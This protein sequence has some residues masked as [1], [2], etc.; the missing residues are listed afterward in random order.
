MLEPSRESYTALSRV[1]LYAAASNN[2]LNWTPAYSTVAGVFPADAAPRFELKR[3][4]E[5]ASLFTSFVRFQLSV[6]TPGKIRLKFNGV[7]G[8]SMWLN[9]NAQDM[10]TIADLNLSSGIITVTLSVDWSKRNDGL[11]IEL[12][13]APASAARAD[14]GRQIIER[15]TDFARSTC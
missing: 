6:T 3:G 2:T 9:G 1:G 13:D 11:R 8:L 10:K 5:N 7:N 12:E 15:R 4:L 14:R